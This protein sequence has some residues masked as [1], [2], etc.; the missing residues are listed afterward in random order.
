MYIRKLEK[1]DFKN[2][3]KLMNQFR[4]IDIEINFELFSNIYDQIFKSSEIYIAILNENIIGSVT[5]IYEKKF[6]NNCA[7]YAHI[8]D[9]IVDKEFRNNKIG[10]KLLDYVKKIAIEKDCFKCTLVCNKNI[11]TFY[12]KNNFEERG[13]NMSYLISK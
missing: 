5:I 1:N 10:S 11:S 4:P 2:Y 13:L 8:E 12:L 3:L 7:L 6:I 9:V